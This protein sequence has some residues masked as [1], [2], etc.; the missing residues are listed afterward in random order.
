MK[1]NPTDQLDTSA[2]TPLLREAIARDQ[3]QQPVLTAS[4]SVRVGGQWLRRYE[5]GELAIDDVDAPA[6]K[7]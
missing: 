2:A 6:S 4:T 1:G 7:K 5:P 3:A